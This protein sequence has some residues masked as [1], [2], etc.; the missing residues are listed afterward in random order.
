MPRQINFGGTI[1]FDVF[2]TVTVPDG[3]DPQEWSRTPEAK[4]A[5]SEAMAEHWE[6]TNSKFRDGLVVLT[7]WSPILE[8]GDAEVPGTEFDEVVEL[9]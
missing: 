8:N 5:I 9:F 2:G 7:D 6:D 4:K 1:S 3:V